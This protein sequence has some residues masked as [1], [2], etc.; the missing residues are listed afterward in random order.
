MAISTCS[1][2]EEKDCESEF[3]D[4]LPEDMMSHGKYWI[5]YR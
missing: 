1:C 4:K 3:Q 2:A 5:C